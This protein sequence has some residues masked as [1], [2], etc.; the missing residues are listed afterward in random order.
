M[1]LLL[2]NMV[3][4]SGR[5]HK[6]KVQSSYSASKTNKIALHLHSNQIIHCKPTANSL[7]S[8]KITS[9]IITLK[10]KWWLG[11]FLTLGFAAKSPS[12]PVS[13]LPWWIQD[14]VCEELFTPK[15]FHFIPQVLG[16]CQQ[17]E[18]KI[19]SPLIRRHLT[20]DN[21][22]TIKQALWPNHTKALYLWGCITSSLWGC[23]SYWRRTDGSKWI[24]LKGGELF[25][26]ETGKQEQ[27][28]DLTFWQELAPVQFI[29]QSQ[30]SRFSKQDL[31]QL[32]KSLL[33]L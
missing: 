27:N 23:L 22:V 15:R 21:E 5:P 25:I 4:Y 28:T 26:K 19:T 29:F 7:R 18:C 9:H 13:Q 17:V 1:C 8:P 10:R 24:S 33:K 12:F 11:T 32:L 16:D 2:I 3:Q 30:S 6:F 31:T 14:N 20:R